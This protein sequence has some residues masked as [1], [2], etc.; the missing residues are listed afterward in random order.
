MCVY[1]FLFHNFYL[2][3]VFFFWSIFTFTHNLWNGMHIFC[4]KNFFYNFFFMNGRLSF[5]VT[6]QTHH[7]HYF[8]YTS[9]WYKIQNKYSTKFVFVLVIYI[10]GA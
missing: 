4:S 2:V 6:S 1:F 10:D 9:I 5:C 3:V 7:T 8:I